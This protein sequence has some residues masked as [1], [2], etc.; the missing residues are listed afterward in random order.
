MTA[1]KPLF[2]VA[3]LAGTSSAFAVIQPG[4][5]IA[6]TAKTTTSSILRMNGGAAAAGTQPEL[7]VKSFTQT[8]RFFVYVYELKLFYFGSF[9]EFTISGYSFRIFH[10]TYPLYFD[11]DNNISK[12]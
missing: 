7:K 5:P 1:L 2:I 10:Q 11:N 9:S 4:F 6:K 8:K 3:L 12:L